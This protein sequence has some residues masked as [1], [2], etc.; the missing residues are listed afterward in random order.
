MAVII[1]E[2]LSKQSENFIVSIRLI[3]GGLSF[4]GYSPNL[5]DSFFFQEKRW[6]SS[7]SDLDHLKD[8]VSTNDFLS[9]PFK[10]LK[11]VLANT[12]YMLVPND[13][14]ADEKELEV[15]YSYTFGKKLSGRLLVDEVKD[16]EMSVLYQMDSD[17]YDF[18]T[19]SFINPEFVHAKSAVLSMWKNHSLSK[20]NRQMYIS[21]ID[22]QLVIACCEK[23]H[24]IFFNYF[25]AQ[26]LNEVVYYIL[27]VW[28]QQHMDVFTD[29]LYY[30]GEALC[31]NELKA[32]LQQYISHIE[33]FEYPSEVYLMGMEIVH[34]PID[35]I[36]LF[37]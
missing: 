8:F 3:P 6:D 33:S 20:L 15:Y 31:M 36:A 18:C 17:I 24:L 28:K 13:L 10:Q 2:L 4:S 30:A 23:G 37:V 16:E 19:E 29:L 9:R 12:D 21:Y 11:V 35:L 1:P 25:N 7:K 5:K 22:G 32:T 26:D 14:P 27:Y 34:A